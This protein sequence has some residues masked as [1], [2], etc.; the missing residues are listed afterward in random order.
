M[1]LEGNYVGSFSWR[2]HRFSPALLISSSSIFFLSALSAVGTATPFLV[3]L[4]LIASPP[5]P[6]SSSASLSSGCSG[7][8][9]CSPLP[10]L[11]ELSE[12]YMTLGSCTAAVDANV[13]TDATSSD[14]S[15]LKR[16]EEAD[17]EEA[18]AIQTV[19]RKITLH[20][21]HYS[22]LAHCAYISYSSTKGFTQVF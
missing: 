14:G 19:R 8:L 7:I 12:R 3:F 16:L 18:D 17:E 11:A 20:P 4:C 13:C 22:T 21:R 9:S 1:Q 15:R 2:S 10:L 6:S 5:S